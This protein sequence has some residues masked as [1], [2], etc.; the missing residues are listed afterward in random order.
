M[1]DNNNNENKTLPDAELDIMRVIWSAGEPLCASDIAKRLGGSRGWKT[2]TVHVLLRRLCERGYL[3]CDR[4]GYIHRYTPLVSSD[5]YC[6]IE[7]KSFLRRIA[8]GSAR[9]MIASLIESELLTDDDIAEL[10][11]ILNRK[12]EQN[13]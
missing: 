9:S 3:E 7:T 1:A 4:S 12:R 5:G 6:V 8:G 13:D 2:A 10:T 11:D